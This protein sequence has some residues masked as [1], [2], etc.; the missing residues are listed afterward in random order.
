M[1]GLA[2]AI[3]VF[4]DCAPKKEKNVDARRKGA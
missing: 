4:F 3:H 2:P 1:A